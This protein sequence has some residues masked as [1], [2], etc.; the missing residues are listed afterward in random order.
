MVEAFSDFPVRA[1]PLRPDCLPSGRRSCGRLAFEA[2][3]GVLS[4][5][6]EPVILW[7]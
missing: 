7:M 1:I 2:F 6:A 3:L 4:W 5:P